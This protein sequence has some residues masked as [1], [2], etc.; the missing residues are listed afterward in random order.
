MALFL[1]T[2]HHSVINYL[3][4]VAMNTLVQVP[5]TAGQNTLSHKPTPLAINL[6]IIS[7]NQYYRKISKSVGKSK[8]V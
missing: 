5:S 7:C 2:S 1:F 3:L 6:I 8:S 4:H